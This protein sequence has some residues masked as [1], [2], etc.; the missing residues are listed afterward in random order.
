M[1]PSGNLPFAER[2]LV[3]WCLGF[4]SRRVGIALGVGLCDLEGAII[5]ADGHHD[6]GHACFEL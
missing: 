2:T 3:G 1:I 6:V 4:E 5:L